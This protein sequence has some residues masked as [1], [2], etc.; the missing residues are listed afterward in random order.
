MSKYFVWEPSL[1]GPVARI[2]HDKQTNGNGK[3]QTTVGDPIL[4]ANNDTRSIEELKRAYPYE[5]K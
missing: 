2:W 4:L 5:E 1:L 3:D